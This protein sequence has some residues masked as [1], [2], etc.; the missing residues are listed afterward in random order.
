MECPN[1][2]RD[3]GETSRCAFCGFDAGE[4][5][6]REMSPMERA[7]YRGITI[8]AGGEPGRDAGGTFFEDDARRSRVFVEGIQLRHTGTWLDALLEN[9]WLL[10]LLLGAVIVAVAGL[11][12]FVALPIMLVVVAVGMAIW[13]LLGLFH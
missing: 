10:R 2:G 4:G 9:R 8:D 6:V 5:S 7:G 3:I 11:L 1:C 13:L 12:V